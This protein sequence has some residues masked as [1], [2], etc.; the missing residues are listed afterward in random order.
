MSAERAAVKQRFTV[1]PPPPQIT[2]TVYL[3]GHDLSQYGY[4]DVNALADALVT[5]EQQRDALARMVRANRAWGEHVNGCEKCRGN[6]IHAGKQCG[7]GWR[8]VVEQ[9]DACTELPKVTP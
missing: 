4:V 7:E 5:A 9:L 6:G 1:A 8:L 3:H 2:S